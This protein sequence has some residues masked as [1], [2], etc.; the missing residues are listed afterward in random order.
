MSRRKSNIKKEELRGDE[1]L[2]TFSDTITLLLTFFI[3]LY[4]F[5]TV[6]QQK[7]QEISTALQ[8]VLSGKEGNTILEYNL[9][10]GQQP[11]IGGKDTD[12]P[13]PQN[14]DE[15]KLGMYETVKQFIDKNKLEST[16]EVKEDERG[17]IIQL[18]DNIL[19]DS[20]R[21]D[22][23]EGSRGVLEKISG[24]M[25]TFPNKI[26]IE[27]HTDNVPIKNSKYDS[28]WELST[29]RAVNV[30]RYFIEEKHQ[31]PTRFAAA[32]YGEYK[33]IA[34]NSAQSGRDQNRRVN[35]L[36]VATEKEKK[37]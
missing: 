34:D 31:D 15:E 22:L 24:L 14:M 8:M 33:P 2:A 10:N 13:I 1:W 26:I 9:N 18:K 21:A 29:S 6:N 30:V 37:K 25:S 36:I 20:G 17:I 3:L 12:I 19:F 11:I 35:I 27:G 16:V 28:N 23:I 5:S 32:G 4:S 7:L